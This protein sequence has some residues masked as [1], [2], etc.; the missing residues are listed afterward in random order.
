MITHCVSVQRREVKLMVCGL[1]GLMKRDQCLDSSTS[2][3]TCTLTN[4]VKKQT[5]HGGSRVL[6]H[7]YIFAKD[8]KLTIDHP[9]S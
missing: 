1:W 7:L 6:L 5:H 9:S 3:C 2:W 8:T 4:H